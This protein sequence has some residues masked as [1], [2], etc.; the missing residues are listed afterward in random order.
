MISR[1]DRAQQS[2]VS[3]NYG[4][5]LRHTTIHIPTARQLFAFGLFSTFYSTLFDLKNNFFAKSIDNLSTAAHQ[6]SASEHFIF[7]IWLSILC[8]LAAVYPK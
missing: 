1:L 8:G 7:L 3:R 4:A 5:T 6:S 2:I